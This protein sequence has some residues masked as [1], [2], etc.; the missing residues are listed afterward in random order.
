M[1]LI[2]ADLQHSMDQVIPQ[3]QSLF[4]VS[5]KRKLEYEGHFLEEVV[6]KN[7]IVCWIKWLRENNKLY[8]DVS[9]QSDLIDDFFLKSRE[10][11]DNFEANCKS[12]E[13]SDEESDTDEEV[14][15]VPLS[16]QY[17]SMMCNKYC[18]EVDDETITNRIA[19]LIVS[20]EIKNKIEVEDEDNEDGP[21]TDE[22]S[23]EDE[24]SFQEIIPRKRTKLSK[25]YVAPGEKGTFQNW[26][27]DIFL[28]EK[29]FPH[30]F[31]YGHGGYLSTCVKRKSPLGFAAYCRNR[32]KSVDP[33]FREDSV[34]IFFLLLIKEKVELKRCR[35]TYLRQAR[36][37]PNLNKGQIREIKPENLERYNKLYSVFKNMRG[38][39]MYYEG[40][41]K[42][43]MATLRQKGSPTLFLTLSAAEFQWEELFH[44]VLETILN[45]HISREELEKMDFTRTERN[46]IIAENVVQTTIYFEKRLQ[47]V[48]TLLTN[49]GFGQTN[50]NE[51]FLVSSYFYRIEFQSRGAPH[52]HA[53]LWLED[54]NGLRAPS[55]WN[56]DV[57]QEVTETNGNLERRIEDVNDLLISCSEDDARCPIHSE[58][59]DLANCEDCEDCGVLKEHVKTFQTHG[60]TFTCKKKKKILKISGN[61]G[62]G[63]NDPQTSS[64]LSV[65]VCRFKFPRFP[66]DKTTLVF[67]INKDTS[68][69]EVFKMKSD[70]LHLKKYLARKTSR[71]MESKE[72][73]ESWK[74]FKQMNFYDFLEDLGMFENIPANLNNLKKKEIARERY[75]NA[76]S[77][78]IKG[79]SYVYLKREPKDVFINNYNKKL[80]P[81][82]QAN[83]DIQYVNDHFACA[84]YITSYLTK[85]ES[86]MSKLLKLCEEECKDLPRMDMLNRFA[87]VLDKHREV[88]I[89]ETIYR[90]LGLAMSKFSSKVKFL[91]TSHPNYRDGLLKGNLDELNEDDSIFHMS[92]HQYY[93]NRPVN[94]MQNTSINWEEMTLAEFWANYEV[95]KSMPSKPSSTLQ[96]LLNNCGFISERKKPAVLRYF[97]NYDEPEE[98]ARGLLILF[99]P[100][101]DE[102]EEIHS[103]DVLELV[104]QNKEFIEEKR[105]IFEMNINLFG[106]MEEIEK[107][108]QEKDEE[109][110]EEEEPSHN[111]EE[112]TTNQFD[113]DDFVMKAKTSAQRNVSRLEDTKTPEIQDIRLRIMSLN[114][115]QR[116]IFDDICERIMSC[117][118]DEKPFYLYIAG[119][120]GT[121]K[122][123]LLRLCIEAVR[124]LKMSSG[125]EINKPKV[126]VMAPTANAAFIVKGKTI[127]SALGLN[128]KSFMN[129]VKPSGER[130]SNLKF[131]Y[132]D[133]N[134]IFLDEVSMVGSAKLT[135]INFQL[136]DL[137]GS[138]KRRDFMGGISFVASGDLRQLPPI[139]DQLITEKN[140]LDGRP[141]CAPSHWDENFKIYYLTEKMRCHSDDQFASLCDRVGMGDIT[142]EDEEYLQSRV[143]E[144]SLEN[145]NENFKNGNISIIVTTNKSREAINLEKLNTL[146]PNE[147][148]YTCFSVD[149][150]MNVPKAKPLSEKLPYT[151]TGQLP[152]KLHIKKGAPIVITTNHTKAIYKED[153]IMNGARGYID[154]IQTSDTDPSQVDIIWVVFKDKENG[155]KYRADHR[156]L[157]G[158]QLLDE[159]ATPILPVKKRFQVK[160]G[161]VE[162]QRRQ[163]ALT[164]AYA[165]TAHKCQGETFDGGVIVDFK[166]GFII[167][168]SFY[169]AITRVREGSKLFLRNFH[170]SYIKVTRG[171]EEKIKVMRLETP[172][173]FKKTYL[174]EQI[175]EFDE[176]DLK[177]GYFNINCLRDSLHGE[178]VNSD[179]NLL[180]LD[181]L[182]LSDTRLTEAVTN[183]E[184]QLLFTNWKVVHR[185]DCDD[186]REHMG[187]LFLIPEGK[188]C[189]VKQT[190]FAF[191]NTENIRGTS[192]KYKGR[193]E[194]QAV[195]VKYAD[196]R[197]SFLYCRTTPS[198]KETKEISEITKKSHYVMGDLNL[199]P[200][201]ET[202]HQKL[203]TI[204]SRKKEMDLNEVTT[205]LGQQLDHILVDKDLRESVYSASY[206]SFASDHKPIILRISQCEN[207]KVIGRNPDEPDK[208]SK[209][210]SKQEKETI[211]STDLNLLD[212]NNWLNDVIINEYTN[213]LT[214][215]FSDIFIF[216]TYFTQSFFTFDRGY[217]SVARYTKS[218]DI[219]ECRVVLFPLLELSH[220]FLAVMEFENNLLYI[221]D[222]FTGNQSTEDISRD[223]MNRLEKLESGYLQ[224]HFENKYQQDW[225]EIQKSVKM[226]P[227]IPEQWDGHNCGIYL[228]EFA[229]CLANGAEFDFSQRDMPNIRRRMK[230]EIRSGHI[231]FETSQN[232]TGLRRRISN[233]DKET[234]WLNSCLQ[235]ILNGLDHSPEIQLQ[236]MLGSELTFAQ[237]ENLI[238]P[239]NIK[240]I[241]QDEIDSNPARRRQEDILTGQQCARDFFITLS[242]NKES[243]LDLYNM[244]HHVTEQTLTCPNCKQ[245]SS[246]RTSQL[247]HELP[248]PPDGAKLRNYVELAFNSVEMVEFLCQDGCNKKG[249]FKKKLNL[250]SK[251]S[252]EFL[253]IV[254]TRVISETL[255]NYNNKVHSTEKVTIQDIETKKL[256][257]EPIAVIEHDGQLSDSAETTGHYVCDVKDYENSSWYTTNDEHVPE[258]IPKKNVTKYGYIILYKK[259]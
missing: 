41:K 21:T 171:V 164:L 92:A 120:A 208:P 197:I 258:L 242:E 228:L 110:D 25:V 232:V 240:M 115:Q 166:D 245:D 123:F 38:T 10:A 229:R 195:H 19:D 193:V 97:L 168:G 185:Q 31:P 108:Q 165:L 8:K 40:I 222:P 169:V 99:Y 95:V 73:E 199:N 211:N 13:S 102:M 65:A 159:F 167:P 236:S 150:V 87:N 202:Q 44:Q 116:R 55:L 114:S 64:E 111:F 53:L 246:L 29:A 233:V 27:S 71:N 45:K 125:D 43:A 46:K 17:P 67:P 80:M 221:L 196:Q 11:A 254:L 137:S 24:I 89:Q 129:Y 145:N 237:K 54:E 18:K 149:R 255:S 106:L 6:D 72:D 156:H 121:G 127:E 88:S 180:N 201:E 16:K 61:E 20:Y 256:T 56:E 205:D 251:E 248:C 207:D 198:V 249:M 50:S 109:E 179:K 183:E 191:E 34:Y 124:Y 216:S 214:T 238:D 234:C 9:F 2:S 82:L 160:L 135:K 81:I 52:V 26:G 217:E 210:S 139:Q 128:P 66:L 213:M 33:R 241:L 85:N 212:G 181:L 84:N 119:E 259:K 101:R 78:D 206:F 14:E 98:L 36:K 194:T 253:V 173:I 219:F 118:V 231:S 138:L 1:I 178:Y 126:I 77:A 218:T 250:V 113:I 103:Q 174:D 224:I 226:P 175:F 220:W 57:Q 39:S 189:G 28:E 147:E 58:E 243:W 107:I 15:E 60:C 22:E 3:E 227:R 105:K 100:F 63:K 30:L 70:L 86:G 188:T 187:M 112:E 142:E 170:P 151:Q 186:G 47:K 7:K 184:V 252:S 5:F 49:E 158:N 12:K 225:I 152:P 204:C 23:E 163:F 257:Y 176:D 247:Y 74:K 140:K 75:L 91:S 144:T 154:H 69:K 48:I 94:T 200:T 239:T 96:P 190:L 230:R 235:L 148:T 62:L 51:K 42:D 90:L 182:C 134:V 132:E 32:I 130:Q 155:A 143:Q 209:C 161:N 153:G 79:S 162:Y 146:L 172:Y 131:L 244:F 35:E 59:A 223:H 157:R 203:Q 83:H 122:S 37:T 4:A 141:L 68:E 76:L 133:V 104:D 192:K 136:Q 117:G 93:E 177:I 215:R